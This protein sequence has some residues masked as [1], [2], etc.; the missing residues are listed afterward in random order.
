[1]TFAFVGFVP[2]ACLFL[3]LL[4]PSPPRPDRGLDYSSVFLAENGAI[5]RVFLNSN[6]QWL[7][8]WP[9]GLSIPSKIE[10]AVVAAE[11]RYFAFHPGIN[12]AAV[13]RALFQNLRAGAIVSGASTITM[14]LARL[15][16]PKPRT[17]GNKLVEVVQALRIEL[18]LDK[19]DILKEYLSYAP[20]GGNVI[21]APAAALR[22]FGK[23]IDALTWAEAATLAVLPRA[24]AAV[25]PRANSSRLETSRN[26]LLE[27]L[28]GEGAFDAE[29][30]R[31]SFAEPVPMRAEPFPFETPHFTRFLY[32]R[33][34]RRSGLTRTYVDIDLQ[35]ELERV[36]TVHAGYLRTL[37]I[38][39]LAVLIVETRSGKIVAYLGSQDYF[40]TS[41]SGAVDGVVASRSS[42]SILKPFL[43]ALS[44][45]A[46]IIVPETML[47]DVPTHFG[48][49]HP[50]NVDSAYYGMI[51]AREALQRSLNVPAVRL[52]RSF[53]YRDFYLFLKRAG[54]T[55]LFR[56][57][58]D[59]GL[60]LIV[61]GAETRLYDL[62][63]LYRGLGS[64]G[65]FGGLTAFEGDDPPES[66]TNLISAGASYLVLDILQDLKRPEGETWWRQRAGA[67]PVAWKTGTSY[68]NRDAWAVGVSP[69]WTVGVWVGNFS[70]EENVN[71]RSASTSAPLLFD[72]FNL[73]PRSDEWF[74]PPVDELKSITICLDTGYLAGDAC[75][76]TGT[77]EV[78]VRARPLGICP[79][80]RNVYVDATEG[81]EVCSLCWTPGRVVTKRLL[82]Y[83]PDAVQYL[84]G[85]G[86]SVDAAPPHNPSCPTVG[87][88]TGDL[89]VVY[90]TEG[91]VIYLP[92]DL[93]GALQPLGVRAAHRDR[94]MRLFW[95]LDGRYLGETI[96]NHALPVALERG[97]H[98]L[99]VIDSRGQRKSVRFSIVA[100]DG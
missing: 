48:A 81:F 29:T 12:P 2:S 71:L 80:H 78:P 24:P 56:R 68:G 8:P 89:A 85:R 33:R 22:Y 88:R 11:D 41:S 60:S 98:E 94:E 27:R 17:L 64:G 38:A 50:K 18:R 74:K 61:G 3:A 55:T 79:Y 4:L 47:I 86:T 10:A 42:G 51:S 97:A 57:P 25:Y 21:G 67:F 28:H 76:R 7:L 72:V 95:Y 43:Y 9:D 15:L 13:L 66:E 40:D 46:G 62:V 65:R 52:L 54:A 59:Y 45:D 84:A 19:S 83:P 69:D 23:R 77:V 70:G 44:I 32:E 35:K 90:P 87:A 100:G 73:L 5:L 20:Y 92:R 37:G 16:D 1:M 30:L 75:E 49:F 6:E 36:A 99:L 93:D 63:S 31:L 39:N 26:R 82:F 34:G 53:G 58:D 96:E 14:Q 91:G